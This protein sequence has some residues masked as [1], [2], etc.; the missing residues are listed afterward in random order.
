MGGAGFPPCYVL[1]VNSGGGNEDNGD[2]PQ[3]IPGMYCYSPRPQLYSRLT[4]SHTFARDS[5]T[6][7]RKSPMQSLLLSPGSWCTSFWCALHESISQSYISSGFSI[8]GLMVT[9]FKRT[10]AILTPKVPDYV[11]DHC[12]S[13][14]PPEMPNTVLSQSLWD[15]WVLVWKRFVW[16]LWESLAAITFDYKCEFAPL[17]V[18][19]S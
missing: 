6:H 13:V 11:P 2:L 4:L 7:T 14:P 12:Q 19:P 5:R 18:L 16:A 15:L 1:G 17:T 9:S 8:V 10:Y 3:K